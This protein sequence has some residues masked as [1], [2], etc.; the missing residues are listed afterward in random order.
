MQKT[1]A[2]GAPLQRNVRQHSRGPWHWAVADD[3]E[4]MPELRGPDGR[5]CWFGND[6]QYYPTCGE[7]PNEA[8]SRLIAAAPELLHA[9]RDLVDVMT[10]RM[11]GETVALHNA[12]DALMKVDGAA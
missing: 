8:D 10:G 3:E 7:P 9:L 5:V 12:L 4:D 11:E 2:G 6:T 1:D